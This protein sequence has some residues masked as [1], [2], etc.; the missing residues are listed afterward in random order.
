MRISLLAALALVACVPGSAPTTSITV[1]ATTTS[2][3]APTTTTTTAL[4]S[5]QIY[6]A[7][8]PSIAFIEGALGTG[9]GI[10]ID[11]SHVLTNLHVIWP[12]AQAS[13][14]FTNG[15]TVADA[16]VVGLDWMAD[17]AL[18]DVS[19]ADSL[20]DPVSLAENVELPIGS[21]VYLVGYPADATRDPI[22]AITAGILSRIRNWEDGEMA[23][24]QS[25]ASISG[26]QSGGA[27]VADTGDVIGLSGLS[28]GEGGLALSLATPDVLELVGEILEGRDR[29]S[30]GSRLLDDLLGE[31]TDRVSIPN[32]LAEAV[33]VFQGAIG[34]PHSF[35]INASRPS[36]VFLTAADGYVEGSLED[37][38][39]E[40]RFE[41]ELGLD[42]PFF[43]SVLPIFDQDV[44][45]EVVSDVELRLMADP[46][47]GRQLT[48]G[49]I[50]YGNADYPGDWD[51]FTIVL[52][53]GDQITMV[54]T[55]AGMD[56]GIAVDWVGNTSEDWVASDSDSAGGVL[57]FDAEVSFTAPV[58][59]DYLVSISDESFY[60]PGAYVVTISPGR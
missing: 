39:V 17:L 10:L 5:R 58:T 53:E 57:G 19:K 43:L 11:D 42:G 47:H 2:P 29:W 41:V 32:F 6:Q 15:E 4:D 33:F 1:L 60:G 37:T 7:L 50:Y 22:P 18:I 36:S 40:K 24:L 16:P 44:E 21:E 25:D 35:T 23:F 30:L 52:E 31:V 3:P 14:T 54:V 28:I 34:D 59:G 8:A 26:G 55:T 49:D 9:S 45:V 12:E 51:W 46:D 13:V 38:D 20:P 48:V 56:P 27:L